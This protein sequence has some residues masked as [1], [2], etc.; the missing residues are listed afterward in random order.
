MNQMKCHLKRKMKNAIVN[1]T[2]VFVVLI[3]INQI[4]SDKSSTSKTDNKKDHK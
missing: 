2:Q 4:K 1:K 3:K